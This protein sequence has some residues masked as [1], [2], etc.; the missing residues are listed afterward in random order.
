MKKIVV[1]LGLVVG[2]LL[3]PAVRDASAQAA[4]V[5]K[6]PFPFI[7]NR[8][9]LPAGEYRFVMARQDPTMMQIIST[10]GGPGAFVSVGLTEPKKNAAESALVFQRVS[11]GYFLSRVNVAGESTREVAVP[12]GAVAARLAMLA[13]GMPGIRG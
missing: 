2:V 9:V 12:H 1:M 11:A 5:A 8:T 10:S 6:V 3:F 7:V 4:T 13:A